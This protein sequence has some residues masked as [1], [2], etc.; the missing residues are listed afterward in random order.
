MGLVCSSMSHPLGNDLSKGWRP[1]NTLS[2]SSLFAFL[3]LQQYLL[4]LSGSS[5]LGLKA[6]VRSIQLVHRESR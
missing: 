4:D 6:P 3:A 1:E 5:G 2:A